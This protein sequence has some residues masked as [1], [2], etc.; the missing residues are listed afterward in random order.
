MTTKERPVKATTG[1]RG[2]SWNDMM[3]MAVVL[4]SLT[5]VGLGTVSYVIPPEHLEITELQPASRV[6][7][8]EEFPVGASRIVT[9][10]ELIIL[11]VRTGEST[12][13]AWCALAIDSPPL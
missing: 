9:W 11:V 13:A 8:L 3:L 7:T 12:F 5:I 4:F 6:A 10:G 1:A 2:L